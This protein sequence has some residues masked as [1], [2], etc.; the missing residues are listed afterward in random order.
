MKRLAK[1]NKNSVTE[2][3]SPINITLF[4]FMHD[5]AMAFLK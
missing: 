5:V 2:K 4:D 1:R 3:E